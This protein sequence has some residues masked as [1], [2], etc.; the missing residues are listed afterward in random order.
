MSKAWTSTFMC[1]GL[2]TVDGHQSVV[3]ASDF[4]HLRY[5]YLNAVE[6]SNVA[7][8][9]HFEILSGFR[10]G[11]LKRLHVEGVVRMTW[12]NPVVDALFLLELQP[13]HQ[14]GI[15]L[16]LSSTPRR[17]LPCQSVGDPIDR[18]GGVFGEHDL[19]GRGSVEEP[20]QFVPS[21]ETDFE[22][23]VP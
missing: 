9:D 12:N 22:T 16:G 19:V 4:R 3:V 15:V 2:G 10:T 5:G 18:V 13:R 8:S 17:L 11:G 14:V 23:A 21:S 7:H 20:S 6:I 1:G